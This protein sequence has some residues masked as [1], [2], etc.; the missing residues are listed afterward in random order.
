MEIYRTVLSEG[1]KQ[2]IELGIFRSD[3]MLHVDSN[4][5]FSI[6]QV[7]LNTIAASFGFLSEK[8]CDMHRY[9]MEREGLVVDV[10]GVLPRNDVSRIA[11]AVVKAR[12]LY[13]VEGSVVLMIVQPGERNVFDQKELEYRLFCKC[14]ECGGVRF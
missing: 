12:E 14:V 5:G 11:E 10:A 9:V 6:K 3:Y 1:I 2:R 13:G 4:K 7:E 8:V